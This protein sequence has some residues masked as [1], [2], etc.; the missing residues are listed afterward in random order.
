MC[1][2]SGSLV[3]IQPEQNWLLKFSFQTEPFFNSLFFVRCFF[4]LFFVFYSLFVL[5][6]FICLFFVFYSVCSLFLL[7]LFVLSL[8]SSPFSTTTLTPCPFPT[9]SIS[10][11]SHHHTSQPSPSP[12]A[13]YNL[14][15]TTLHHIPSHHTT[16]HPTTLHSTPPH[17]TPPHHTSLSALLESV[18]QQSTESLVF[19][20]LDIGVS[21]MMCSGIS[22]ASDFNDPPGQWGRGLMRGKVVL[23]GW[24]SG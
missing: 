6:F 24:G 1:L 18:R 12:C 15:P 20:R 5:C 9:V 8:T 13:T 10:L 3:S 21:A 2:I 14:H 4:F 22:Q 19:D 23:G 11:F 16:L 17:Y 7:V